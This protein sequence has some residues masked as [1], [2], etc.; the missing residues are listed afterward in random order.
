MAEFT[1]YLVHLK[2]ALVEALKKTFDGDF[3]DPDFRG[4]NVSIEYPVE[5]QHYPGIWVDYTDSASL[6]AAG[7]DHF[8]FTEPG[9]SGYVRRF[10]R[11]R[12]AGYASFTVVAL[13]SL[14][15]DRLFD[16]LVRVMAFTHETDQVPEFRNYVENNEFIAMN[17]D[18]DEIEPRGNSVAPGTPWGSDELIYEVTVNMEVI[19]EFISEGS[20]GTLAPLSTILVTGRMSETDDLTGEIDYASDAPLEPG[21]VLVTDPVPDWH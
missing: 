7:I 5:P 8:E 18:F 21:D 17:F 1:G 19:G 4:I 10:T 2:T 16:Q 11:W 13:T 20:T 6:R 9:D 14:E 12:F 3:P 15:R